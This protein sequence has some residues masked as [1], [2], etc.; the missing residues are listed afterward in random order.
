MESKM[1]YYYRKQKTES[2]FGLFDM[3]VCSNCHMRLVK[4]LKYV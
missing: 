4:S 2:L 3:K 1:I